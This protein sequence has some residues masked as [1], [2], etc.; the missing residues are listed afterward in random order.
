MDIKDLN[1]PQTRDADVS[2][3]I[4]NKFM[5]N[6]I[7]AIALLSIATATH[8]QAQSRSS[9]DL[10][11]TCIEMAIDRGQFD[12]KTESYCSCAVANK[13]RFTSIK[14]TAKYCYNIV[15]QQDIDRR[16]R[17]EEQDLQRS[18]DR[19]IER[20]METMITSPNPYLLNWD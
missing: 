3:I 16:R 6:I 7:F 13:N 11:N 18:H 2:E 1:I 14:H 9:N 4:K 19:L 20:A 8:A 5:K 12:E 15:Y 17:Q 10:T